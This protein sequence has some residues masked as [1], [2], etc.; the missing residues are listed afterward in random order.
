M[1]TLNRREALKLTVASGLSTLIP[2]QVPKALISTSIPVSTDMFVPEEW[3]RESYA[4]L[5]ESMV[6]AHTIHRQFDL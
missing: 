2:W 3:A 5:E 6:V 1:K 4:I